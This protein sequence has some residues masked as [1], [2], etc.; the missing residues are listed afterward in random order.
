MLRS[1]ARRD[2]KPAWQKARQDDAGLNS[3]NA[4][5]RHGP[6]LAEKYSYVSFG[7]LLWNYPFLRGFIQLA[8]DGSYWILR[9]STE[10]KMLAVMENPWETGVIL[11]WQLKVNKDTLRYLQQHLCAQ[12]DWAPGDKRH[13]YLADPMGRV[14]LSS[15]V[16]HN[17]AM[18]S[19]AGVQDL[20]E[21]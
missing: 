15:F 10:C 21:L 2:W 17:V 11:D 9:Y 16:E 7:K 8:K 3:A 19:T 14:K 6:Q 20:S 13:W 12:L 1:T 4:L 5:G 18:D